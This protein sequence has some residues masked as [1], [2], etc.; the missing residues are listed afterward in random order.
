MNELQSF[1]VAESNVLLGETQGVRYEWFDNDGNQVA[2]FTIF[3]WWDGKNICNL[4][5]YQKYRQMGYTRELLDFATKKLGCT[6]LAV[7]KRNFVAK[8]IYDK[9]GFEV[10]DKDENLYYMSLTKRRNDDGRNK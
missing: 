6:C 2:T 10:I 1:K 9:Y 7:G 8:H 4:L 5:V 3:D